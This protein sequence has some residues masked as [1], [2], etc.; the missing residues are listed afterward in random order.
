MGGG[1][2][3]EKP[4]ANATFECGTSCLTATDAGKHGEC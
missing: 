4:N 3:I 2:S 1:F